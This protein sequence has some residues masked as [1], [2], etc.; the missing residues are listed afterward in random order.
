M[1]LIDVVCLKGNHFIF[2][3]FI[4]EEAH[5]IIRA[6]GLWRIFCQLC[7]STQPRLDLQL[8]DLTAFCN[9]AAIDAIDQNRLVPQSLSGEVAV[10]ADGL[11]SFVGNT[12][13]VYKGLVSGRLGKGLVSGRGNTDTVSM[14]SNLWCYAVGKGILRTV[15]AHIKGCRYCDTVR[16]RRCD[17]I[18]DEAQ[19][20]P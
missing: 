15:V 9:N 11:Y 4:V 3:G 19:N 1:K 10:K 16:I 13:S 8:A 18:Y 12:G 6:V 14:L 5:S 2:G 7:K 20:A 17:L